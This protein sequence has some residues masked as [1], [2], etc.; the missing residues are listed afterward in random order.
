MKLLSR[1]VA[2]LGIASTTLVYPALG[3]H[4]SAQALPEQQALQI[5]STVP[6]FM[7]TDSKGEPLVAAV[8]DPKDKNKQIQRLNFYVSPKDAQD[9][10]NYL[11][12]SNPAVGSN[13]KIAPMS[14]NSV[15]EFNRKNAAAGVMTQ[16]LPSRAQVDAAVAM[17]RQNGDVKD[18]G[19]QLVGKDGKPFQISTP[20]FV[21][22]DAQNDPIALQT[23][24]NENGK[25][26]L[27]SSF[28]FFFSKQDAQLL[29]DQLRKRDPKLASTTKIN[30]TML[31]SVIS[32]LFSN[33]SP[34][35]AQVELVAANESLQ[36]LQR[37]QG[38]GAPPAR[39]A[40]APG[41]RPAPAPATSPANQMPNVIT[42]TGP[43]APPIRPK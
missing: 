24:V 32:T 6:L 10:L 18:Q 30:V 13:A 17:L 37:L 35:T 23:K 36:Y 31:T 42:P 29:L 41:S 2:I 28:P 34:T 4:M 43:A 33:N 39:P 20:L 26:K 7:I 38:G 21:V 5:L 12:T 40:A 9:A 14:L 3:K 22:T 19:G 16:V 1:W 15:L 8:P 27:V 25:P 11:R